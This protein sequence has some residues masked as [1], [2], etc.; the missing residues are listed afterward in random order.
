MSEAGEIKKKKGACPFSLEEMTPSR[1]ALLLGAGVAS[2]AALV[3]GGPAAAQGSIGRPTHDHAISA[4]SLATDHRHYA[5]PH[6]FDNDGTREAQPF[7]GIHQSGVVNPQP[8]AAIIAAFDVLASERADLQRLFRDLTTRIADLMKGGEVNVADPRMPPPDNLVLGPTVFPDNLTV[9]VALGASLFDG[10]YGFADQ[11]PKRLVAMDQFP[12]DALEA[13]FSHGDLLLQFCSNTSETN[14]HAL[15]EII[16]MAPDALAL[17]WKMD[18]FLPPH[19]LKKLGKDTI[20]NLMGFKDGTANINAQDVNL[21]DE[22]VWV[23]GKH[24]EPEWATAG[25]YQVVRLIRMLVERWD[26][27]PLGEQQTIIGREKASGAPL[28]MTHERDL[29]DYGGPQGKTIPVDA[30]IRLA[31]PRL[32]ET[33]ANLMLRRPYN[34]SRDAVTKAGQ[35]DMGLAFICFQADL[36]AGFRTVQTRLNGEPL[37]EYIRPFGGGYFFALPGVRDSAD[38]FAKALIER[39]PA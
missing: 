9:T 15:R 37:E 11:K 33:Q 6:D 2:G 30:H 14:I 17:R 28:G 22:L 20:R 7:Y 21:M 27:T 36:D 12:N 24:G 32:P 26:R 13:S 8:A 16:R 23:G 29:P 25:S 35:L 5:E 1:R 38:Y 19:T 34:F 18:G 31:N 4:E 10:R 39:R 3:R